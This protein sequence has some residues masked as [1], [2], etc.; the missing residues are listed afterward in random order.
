MVQHL[1]NHSI[2]FLR[3]SKFSFG[4]C[5]LPHR[6][7]TESPDPPGERHLLGIIRPFQAVLWL[8]SHEVHADR[9]PPVNSEQLTGTRHSSPK[10][11]CPLCEF[12]CVCLYK[13][14]PQV[15]TVAKHGEWKCRANEF[16]SQN[17]RLRLADCKSCAC[18]QISLYLASKQGYK[19]PRQ[20][21]GI[22]G[23]ISA[24]SLPSSASLTLPFII[25]KKRIIV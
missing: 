14:D 20:V 24:F 19:Q 25:Y 17:S 12:C 13:A 16:Q 1:P 9:L 11:Q 22:L 18:L 2:L 21:G 15:W 3:A 8:P 7:I 23:L 6:H 4:K 5:P 10:K